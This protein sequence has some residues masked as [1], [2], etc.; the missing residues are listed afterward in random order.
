MKQTVD[1][2]YFNAL[3]SVEFINHDKIHWSNFS[4]I[5]ESISF[6]KKNNV[7]TILDIG[8]GIGKFCILG[9]MLSNI[10]F[11]GVEI[12]KNL[13][14]EAQRIKQQN[15]LSGIHFINDDIKNI[16]FSPFDAFYYYN[17]FCE[18][19]ATKDIID[20]QIDLTEEKY[21]QYEN[22]ILQEM[23]KMI[24]GTIVILHNAKA[25]ILSKNYRL[26]DVL[27][28]GELTFWVKEN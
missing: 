10:Q 1:D 18:H 15:N 23:E 28:N 12:R 4:V 16:D 25:F 3:T 27:E 13:H 14:D 8:S 7:K 17:P 5:E 11:S 6:L 24:V 19:I 20:N 26:I 21:Y 9:T 2:R 22:F